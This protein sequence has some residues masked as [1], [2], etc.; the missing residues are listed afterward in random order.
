MAIGWPEAIDGAPRRGLTAKESFLV[1]RGM[2]AQPTGEE[3]S[4][5]LLRHRRS[6][7]QPAFGQIRPLKRPFGAVEARSDNGEDGDRPAPANRRHGNAHRLRFLPAGHRR[8]I[9]TLYRQLEIAAPDPRCAAE[10]WSGQGSRSH[11]GRVPGPNVYP[12]PTLQSQRPQTTWAVTAI[13]GLAL[14][15]AMTTIRLVRGPGPM[16]P[17]PPF[18]RP[19]RRR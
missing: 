3:S 2:T 7:R 6:R 4:T 12:Q 10:V 1:S 17:A 13:A 18:L 15:T 5:P 19:A 16:G 9:V 11:E 14:A 8:C